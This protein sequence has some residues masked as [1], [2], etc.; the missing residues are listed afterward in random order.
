MSHIAKLVTGLAALTLAIVSLDLAPQLA[1]PAV[2]VAASVLLAWF[3]I[4]AVIDLLRVGPGGRAAWWA[5]TLAVVV[6]L[7][8]IGALAFRIADP[9]L[10]REESSSIDS[11]SAW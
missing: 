9:P 6:L 1:W 11:H 3:W 8:P 2:I 5:G 7:G 4:R 10:D